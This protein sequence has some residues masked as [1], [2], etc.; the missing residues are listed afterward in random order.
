MDGKQTSHKK[1]EFL[2]KGIC[3]FDSD[4]ISGD[5]RGMSIR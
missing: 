1:K 5:A 4:G 2:Q 3:I